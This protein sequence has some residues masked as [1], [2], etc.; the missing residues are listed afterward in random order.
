M[1][2][3]RYLAYCTNNKVERE[4]DA[5]LATLAD[6]V[7]LSRLD[8]CCCHMTVIP[9][10]L[11]AWW[12][13]LARSDSYTAQATSLVHPTF[14]LSSLQV[15]DMTCS[16]DGKYVFTAGGSD[17]A[18]NM[19]SINTEYAIPNCTTSG[20]WIKCLPYRALE[21]ASLLGGEDLQPFYAMLDGGRDGEFF[22]E[23][24]EYFYYAQ[25]RRQERVRCNHLIIPRLPLILQ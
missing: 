20:L 5:F 3:R 1:E 4:R 19:W 2:V 18:V 9:T 6:G 11:S 13:T 21:A 8:C 14:L 15:A 12:L 24:E 10:T 17:C 7:C 22:N 23:L 16:F 25:I